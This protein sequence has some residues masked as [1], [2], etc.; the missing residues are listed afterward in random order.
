[1]LW[2]FNQIIII[3]ML[4][5]FVPDNRL[6]HLAY[7]ASET[8]RPVVACTVSAALLKNWCDISCSPVA[9]HTTGIKWSAKYHGNRICYFI[10]YSF[11]NAWR[12]VVVSGNRYTRK[13]RFGAKAII[14]VSCNF[15]RKNWNLQA[16]Y[17]DN[18]YVS[19]STGPSY[20]VL[21]VCVVST[22]AAHWNQVIICS[23]RNSPS[24][25]NTRQ[26]AWKQ[27]HNI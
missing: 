3:K 5:K 18:P 9:W 14:A 16:Y 23:R 6:Y 1:M 27:F 20:V 13:Q 17:E 25:S 2:I 8:H 11:E 4:N 12:Q 19:G 26:I 22:S 24:M 10:W 15:P 21:A 7:L